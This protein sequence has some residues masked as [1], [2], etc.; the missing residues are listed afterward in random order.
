MSG[1]VSCSCG[2]CFCL[3][4]AKTAAHL[5]ALTRHARATE[6]FR[7]E[8]KIVRQACSDTRKD[9][10]ST[11]ETGG[12]VN[13]LPVHDRTELPVAWSTLL[14]R[15]P[16]KEVAS[17][18]KLQRTQ[19]QLVSEIHSQGDRA[20]GQQ[21]QARAKKQQQSEK[22]FARCS[23]SDRRRFGEAARRSSG[24]AADAPQLED[25]REEEVAEAAGHVVHDKGH[26]R[27]GA[28]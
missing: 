12:S 5:S 16:G 7:S 18:A 11:P 13:V 26:C 19:E 9:S 25:A 21:E 10:N 28:L 14:Y 17:E 4:P 15:S 8:A 27:L 22:H 20:R 24:A 1:R 2:C 3:P 6:V 23:S